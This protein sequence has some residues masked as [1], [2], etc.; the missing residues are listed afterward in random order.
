MNPDSLSLSKLAACFD[1]TMLKPKA[2]RV[3]IEQACNEARTWKTATVCVHPIW[4]KEAAVQLAGSKIPVCTVIGFPHGATA[5]P[6]LQAETVRGLE[7]GAREFEVVIPYGIAI[8]EGWQYVVDNVGAV[9]QAA[10]TNIVKAILETSELTGDQIRKAAIAAIRGG[11][12]SLSTSTGFAAAG[13]SVK[14]LKLLADVAD[15]TVGVKAS[16]GIRNYK[17]ALNMLKAG[18]TRLGSS[19]TVA[20]LEEA[21]NSLKH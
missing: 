6:S 8:S 20:I 3:D 1:L 11:A 9:K 13:A 10:G 14:A 12:D 17:D 21:R 19:S 15:G 7:D 2:N 5:Y 18:A 16:G 4:V